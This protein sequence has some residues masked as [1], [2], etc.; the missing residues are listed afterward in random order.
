[1]NDWPYVYIKFL[2]SIAE[3]FHE[4]PGWSLGFSDSYMVL[5][6]VRS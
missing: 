3:P 1:M 4:Y 2:L 5:T 6:E